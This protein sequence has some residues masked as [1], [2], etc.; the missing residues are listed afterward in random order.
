M[1]E[2]ISMIVVLTVLTAV[3]GGLLAKVQSST[4]VQIENQVLKFQKAPAIKS[5]FPDVANDPIADRFTVEADDMKLQV[6]PTKLSDGSKAVAFETKGTGFG[7]PVGLMV[8]VNLDSDKVI[9]VR[10]T[11][12]AETPGIG[13]KA[14]DDLSFVS[15]FTA[16]P[17]MDTNFNLKGSGGVIDAISGATVTSN[18]ICLAAVNAK[19][20]Y[21][22]LK[23]EIIKQMK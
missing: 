10:M 4:E 15:Q 6:F 9:D 18:A 5:I 11:T 16:L 23:P 8:A 21:Q 7:G 17:V 14:K 20:I 1:R 22:K 3:S 2:M 13:T 12:H 19:E